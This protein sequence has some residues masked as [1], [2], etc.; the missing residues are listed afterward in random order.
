MAALA[1]SPEIPSVPF[2]PFSD[3]PA[4][5]RGSIGLAM[6]GGSLRHRVTPPDWSR[7]SL[8]ETLSSGTI[9]K[10]GIERTMR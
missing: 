9:F 3:Y 7:C 5:G 8:V 2:G 10:E 4:L 1:P 6:G